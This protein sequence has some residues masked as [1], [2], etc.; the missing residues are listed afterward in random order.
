LKSI[1]TNA[2][3]EDRKLI[4][5]QTE[6]RQLIIIK[7]LNKVEQDFK[8]TAETVVSK[9]IKKET[10]GRKKRT[11]AKDLKDTRCQTKWPI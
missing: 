6:T 7:T 2:T 1:V 10:V 9:A 8:E 3:R 4:H 5:V 11:R